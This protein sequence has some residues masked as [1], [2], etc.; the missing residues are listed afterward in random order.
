M[1]KQQ[2]VGIL[3]DIDASINKVQTALNTLNKS[4]SKHSA[5]S[6][7]NKDLERIQTSLTKLS[8]HAGQTMTSMSDVKKVTNK[9]NTLDEQLKTILLKIEQIRANPLEFISSEETKKI[10]DA[11]K[12]IDKYNKAMTESERKKA[13]KEKSKENSE[14]LKIIKSYE[15][16]KSRYEGQ[17]KVIEKNKEALEE[18]LN[19]QKEIN[20]LG[21]ASTKEE[22][23]NN[24]VNEEKA[25]AGNKK[26]NIK[27]R[28]SFKEYEQNISKY[29]DEEGN[30]KS[31]AKDVADA[32]KEVER[33]EKTLKKYS[34]TLT[35]T[36]SAYQIAAQATKEFN[37]ELEKNFEAK[38]ASEQVERL[39]EELQK[40]T[41]LDL[42]GKSVEELLSLTGNL[43]DDAVKRLNQALE[44]TDNAAREASNGMAVLE[45]VIDDTAASTEKLEKAD[46]ELENIRD[47][48]TQLFGLSGAINIFRRA[49]SDAFNTVKELDAAMTETAV[50][51]DF[52]VGDMWDEL[53]KYTE[54]ARELG[55]TIQGTYETMTLFFQQG[56]NMQETF[57]VGT[58]TMKMARI[59]NLDY[60]NA[61][62]LMTA[63]L[64]GFNMEL[65]AV[66]AQNV[67]DVYSELAAITASDTEE[68]ATAMT[69]TASIAHSANMEFET[70]AAFLAQMIN[71][72]TYTRVA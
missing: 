5:F 64:R 1:S 42:S 50:V 56:L 4:T 31:F 32:E 20:S 68:I 66:S 19:L 33:S 7:M 24:Y 14:N 35:R 62:D 48:L 49:I 47:G 21:L 57:E 26:V 34:D 63:A 67:N 30:L 13:K 45:D 25:K 39:R 11:T 69:K 15:S 6:G 59:A 58:E 51:T 40:I 9:Y 52:S 28:K 72:A 61:T 27:N 16:Q 12:A 71:F 55:A 22:Q 37:E 41:N 18:V 3:L 46:A 2:K 38:Y 23:L 54:T 53:P 8:V 43:K 17:L 36:E 44:K 70:T 65:N 10:N 29:Y 60:A